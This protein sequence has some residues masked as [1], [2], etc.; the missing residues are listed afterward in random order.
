MIN[1]KPNERISVFYDGKCYVCASEIS[2]YMKKD[3]G[4]NICFVDISDK[5]FDPREHGLQG[6]DIHVNLHVKLSNGEIRSGVEAF[7]AIWEHLPGFSIL[8]KILGNRLVRPLA[9]FGYYLFTRIR[10]YLPRKK[11]EITENSRCASGRD[12]LH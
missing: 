6:R 10:P 12:G 7:I 11:G 9:G 3:R 1:S 5:N 8:A 4:K 2:L